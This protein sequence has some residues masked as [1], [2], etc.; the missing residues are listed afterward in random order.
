MRPLLPVTRTILGMQEF[1]HEVGTDGERGGPTAAS[2]KRSLCF[3]R[4]VGM[5]KLLGLSKAD[6]LGGGG[7]P[8]PPVFS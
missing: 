4:S 1:S 8:P 6:D 2:W 5:D 7:D 3:R